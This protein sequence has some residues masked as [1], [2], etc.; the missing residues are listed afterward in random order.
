MPESSSTRAISVS[1]GETAMRRV[2]SWQSSN[3]RCFVVEWIER[4]PSSLRTKIRRVRRF[5]LAQPIDALANSRPKRQKLD[6]YRASPNIAHLRWI[7]MPWQ[8]FYVRVGSGWP[9]IR[10]FRFGRPTRRSFR[11]ILPWKANFHWWGS[12]GRSRR[13]LFSTGGGDLIALFWKEQCL[14]VYKVL[15]MT[16]RRANFFSP[17]P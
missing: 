7:A 10:F 5:L 3:W 17:L 6:S 15:S 11:K 16:L 9:S 12:I 1:A 13:A 8:G 14:R 2:P 4:W